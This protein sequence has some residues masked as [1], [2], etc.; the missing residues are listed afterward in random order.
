M[1]AIEM[2]A[3]AK[4]RQ[5]DAAETLADQFGEHMKRAGSVDLEDQPRTD[6]PNQKAKDIDDDNA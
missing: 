6:D 3:S 2:G 1:S 5:A 4:M